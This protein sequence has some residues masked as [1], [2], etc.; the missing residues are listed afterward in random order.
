MNI[1]KNYNHTL[2]ACYLGYITQAI[3]N[4]FAPL[5]F[6]TFQSTYEISLDKIALLVS[7]NFG[8]QLIVDLLAAK[9]VDKIGYRNSVVAAHIFGAVGLVG[10]AV[11]PSVFPDAYAGLLLAVFCYAIGGGLI[12]VLIISAIINVVLDIVFIVNFGMGVE[13]CGY[14]TVIAQ[15]VSALL[16]LIYIVK[17]FPILRLSEEDFRISF[18][19][20]GRLLALGIPMGLQFSITAIGTIIVQGAVNIYGAVYMAGFSAAGKLQNI[21]VTVFTA[22]GATVATYVGQ[23]RGAGKMDRVHKGVRYTQI[24][25]FVW[26]A[27]TM[28]LVYFFGE[29]MTLLFV[30]KTETEVLHAAEV[31]FRTVFWAYPFLGSIFIYRNALQGM[32][33]GLVPMLGGVFELAARAL[34]V[35]LVAGKTSFF[36]VCLADPAAWISALIPLIPYYIYVM[37]KYEKQK[38]LEG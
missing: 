29:E 17:K 33:Y 28:V 22:F 14:A 31:Y 6:L 13:G 10:L 12:E 18:Q 2:N 38:Q 27:V 3:V 36:G 23:N 26:S 32:G 25:V 37:K 4:N 35:L 7:F 9:Y 11:F 30:S 21:I 34:I 1:R 8:V 5:L 24:M 20:M 15:A 19:S 16:C